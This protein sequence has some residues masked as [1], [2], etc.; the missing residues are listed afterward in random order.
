MRELVTLVGLV[1]VIACCCAGIIVPR[2]DLAQALRAS[3]TIIVARVISGQAESNDAG[4]SARLVLRVV[5]VLKGEVAVGSELPI[6]T[7]GNRLYIPGPGSGMPRHWTVDHFTALW[8]LRRQG[9][10]YL[11]VPV[12]PAAGEPERASLELPED[13]SVPDEPRIPGLP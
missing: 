6:E 11:V 7:R 10:Q 3:D 2:P 13:A 4:A 5:R 1:V 9:N 8:F 12:T